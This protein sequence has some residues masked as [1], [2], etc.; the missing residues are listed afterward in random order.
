MAESLPLL[1]SRRA[2]LLRAL[3]NLK[4]MG[5]QASRQAD[6]QML[7]AETGIIHAGRVGGEVLSFVTDVLRRRRRIVW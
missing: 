6:K 3:A 4:D 7:L 2:D 1:E 5:A